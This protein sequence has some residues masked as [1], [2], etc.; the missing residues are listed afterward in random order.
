VGETIDEAAGAA[1]EAGER[2]K[3]RG[4]KEEGEK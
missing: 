2:T 4:L 1:E 3:E